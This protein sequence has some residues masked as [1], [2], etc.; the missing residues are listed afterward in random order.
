MVK[1][2]VVRILIA[3]AT[4]VIGYLLMSFVVDDLNTS[5]WGVEQ[6][7]TLA[8]IEA[9]LIFLLASSPSNLTK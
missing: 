9:I 6:R 1:E 7:S 3:L 2:V 4:F 8:I 5:H